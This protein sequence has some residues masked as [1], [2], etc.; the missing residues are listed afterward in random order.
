MS[1]IKSSMNYCSTSS[2]I[3][4]HFSDVT[5]K[6]H[7]LNNIIDDDRRWKLLSGKTLILKNKKKDFFFL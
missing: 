5:N 6:K 3:R 2:P 4:V 7:Q 1:E